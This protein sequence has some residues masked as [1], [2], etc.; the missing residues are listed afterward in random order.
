M[1]G[2]QRSIMDKIFNH[3]CEW[4]VERRKWESDNQTKFVGKDTGTPTR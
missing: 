3:K 2:K 4:E 1:K